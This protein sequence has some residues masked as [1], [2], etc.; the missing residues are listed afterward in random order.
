MKIGPLALNHPLVLKSLASLRTV[1]ARLEPLC[2]RAWTVLNCNLVE[3][4]LLPERYLA[5]CIE[6]GGI[7]AA[8]G[9]RFLNRGRLTGSARYA[10][11]ES[12]FPTPGDLA[13]AV[14][15]A[16]NEL[17][18]RGSQVLLGIPREWVVIRTAGLPSTV[19]ENIRP[20]VAYEIDR[21][22]PLTAADAMHD[23]IIGTE[24]GERLSITLM[25]ARWETLNPYVAALTEKGFPPG[26]ISTPSVGIARLCCRLAGAEAFVSLYVGT[27]GYEGWSIE[28]GDLTGNFYGSLDE[29]GDEEDAK[30]R[31]DE[32]RDLLHTQSAAAGSPLLCLLAEKG[33]GTGDI[34]PDTPHRVIKDSEIMSLFKTSPEG[35]PLAPAAM[36][37]EAL[38]PGIRTFD[39]AR[40][41][42]GGKRRTSLFTAL[43]LAALLVMMV[44]PYVV[45][46]IEIQK[47]RIDAIE[48]QIK[49]RR[50]DVME[51]EGLKKRAEALQ[52]EIDE[53]E[54]FKKKRP[55][56]L[57]VLKGLT[58]LLPKAA[59]LTRTRIT[60]ETVEIEGYAASA[61]TV[62][63]L[64]E[65]SDIFRKV[66]FASPTVKDHRLN[67]ERFVIRMELEGFRKEEAKK[68]ETVKKDEAKK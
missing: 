58:S 1:R 45:V 10:F 49:T 41:N 55:M 15:R 33:F 40:G 37:Y 25:A 27:C 7:S 67:S 29:C 26:R 63:S 42:A 46:P 44:I 24:A 60:E 2:L 54:D 22:T 35:V 5:V 23:F 62:L 13:T 32:M 48:G 4:I 59:W 34:L 66:E 28:K 68:E 16:I 39:L 56:L 38:S 52:G 51:V 12:E 20:V 47:R 17:G 3:G 30:S 11:E 6:R 65:E 64:L 53:I 61:T 50:K 18:H 57:N 21:L 31:Y 19:K 9:D 14:S 43:V 8:S 36:L